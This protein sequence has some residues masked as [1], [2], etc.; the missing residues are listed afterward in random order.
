M[1]AQVLSVEAPVRFMEKGPKRQHFEAVWEQATNPN[2]ALSQPQ[3]S[4]VGTTAGELPVP[5]RRLR[6]RNRWDRL[7]EEIENISIG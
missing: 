7:Q 4:S 6:M 5:I 2:D 1:L 3:L